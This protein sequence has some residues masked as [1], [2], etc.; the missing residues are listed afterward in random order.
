MAITNSVLLVELV[1]SADRMIQSAQKA[2]IHPDEWA[3][4]VVVGHLSQ[5]D[6]EVWLP[7]LALMID[8]QR[9]GQPAPEFGWWEPDGKATEAAFCD[10][11]V[12]ASG[13]QL[14]ASRTDMVMFLKDLTAEQWL[15]KAIHQNFGEVTIGEILFQILKHDEE[16]RGSLVA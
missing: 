8:A 13:A 11:S 6:R 4:A 15:A 12:D 16:H 10:M 7:R 9:D 14:L 2:Q 1:M 3:P 5:V